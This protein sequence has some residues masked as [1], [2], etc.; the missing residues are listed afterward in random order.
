MDAETIQS[1]L[2]ELCDL[3]QR[4][5]L[6][7]FRADVEIT[8]KLASGFDPVTEADR[9]AE[10]VI[11]AAILKRYPDHGIVGEEFGTVNENARYKW[12]IDPVDGTKAFISG[13]PLWGTLIGLY[14][15]NKP[16]AGVMHQPFIEERFICNGDK[17]VWQ[18]KGTEKVLSTSETQNLNDAIIMTTTPALFTAEE[19]LIYD[20]LESQCRLPRYGAD[21]YAYCVLAAGHVDLVVESGLN[22]YDIAALVPIVEKAGGCF[23]DWQGKSAADGGQVIAAANP[24]LHMKALEV[25]NSG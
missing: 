13:L 23:T 10:S 20:R 12:I 2:N 21:C 18:H 1:F 9:E 15:E 4:E 16:L 19:R 14:L 24:E 5:T 25:L 17:S 6:S 8:N 22:S 3:A 7:R 11:R